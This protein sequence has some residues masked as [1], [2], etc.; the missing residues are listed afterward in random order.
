MYLKV[1]T[2][3]MCGCAV[4][5]CKGSKACPY[6]PEGKALASRPVLPICALNVVRTEPVLRKWELVKHG[7]DVAHVCHVIT[8]R[9]HPRCR[10]QGVH[11]L[12]PVVDWVLRMD[13][14]H[15]PT[16]SNMR[17]TVKL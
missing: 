9:Q 10:V 5:T 6:S 1:G 2:G 4:A 17:E 15:F 7:L 14:M 16:C 12:L 11:Q 8:H 13:A 3:P